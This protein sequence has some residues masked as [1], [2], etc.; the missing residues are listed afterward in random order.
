MWTASVYK[1]VSRMRCLQKHGRGMCLL[2]R[3]LYF[4]LYFEIGLW[5]AEVF[6]QFHLAS[7]AGLEPEILS[8]AGVTGM[9]RHDQSIHFTNI[10][11]MLFKE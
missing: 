6:C 3:F 4:C 7:Q 8:I 1:F 9:N 2:H 5:Y 11:N 10:G